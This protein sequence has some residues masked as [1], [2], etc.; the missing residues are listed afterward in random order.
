MRAPPEIRTTA[1]LR[2]A[3][4]GKLSGY[5]AVF[6]SR[7]RDL[8]GFTESIRPGAFA[9]SLADPDEIVALLEHDRRKPLGRVGARTLTLAEDARGLAFEI[10]LPDTTFG[11]DLGTSVAR[12]DVAGASFAFSV[13][14]GGER[15]SRDGQGDHRELLEVRLHE[16]TVTSNPAYTDTT[17]AR[18]HWLA[19]EPINSVS[20]RLRLLELEVA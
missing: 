1:E 20:L 14:E 3:G 2:S 12:G 17:V 19:R 10:D 18:R 16:I 11:R 5:A 15:W 9:R 7:S 8:G 4:L 13:P 6:N